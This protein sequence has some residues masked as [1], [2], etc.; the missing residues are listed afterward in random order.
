V[1][2]LT[3]E[4]IAG[5]LDL[6]A[7]IDALGPA[8]AD[9]SAGRASAPLRLGAVVPDV[10][11]RLLAMPGFVPSQGALVT[12]L[13]SL[14]PHN[15][16][17]ALPTHQA[18]IAVFDPATGAPT[19]LLDGTVI[20]AVRTG[21]CSALS[22]R[23][24]AR[25]DASVLAVLGTGVQA[26][27]HARAVS[28]VRPV[29]EI[30][31]AGRNPSRVEALVAELQKELD[32]EVRAVGSYR[33]ASHGAHIVCATTHPSEPVI[34]REWLDAGAHV[35]SV[36]WSATG[37]EVDDATVADA[38]VVVESR[39]AALAPVT[40][41]GTPDLAEPL[42]DGILGE[43][44]IVELG[45]LAAGTRPGR[46]SPEQLT[47]YKS[48]GVAVQDATAATLVL[49]AARKAGAGRELAL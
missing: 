19:A 15:A 42:R 47:L 18:V 35:T 21:A 16:G 22:A 37:R 33:E 39:L 49:A 43:G 36:G 1:L 12:K 14:F 34:R 10:D 20:T 11:G 17:S 8:M 30:R 13:V 31:V 32:A 3:G 9:L 38:L 2:V 40:A 46:T 7:L 48:V 29:R 45:E 6:D 44:D 25:E 27:S 28:R 5:L 41:A 26:R 23:L 4:E 24:L